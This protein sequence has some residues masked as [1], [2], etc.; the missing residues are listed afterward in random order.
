MDIYQSTLDYLMQLPV[1]DMWPGMKSVL[2]RVA[3]GRP[4]AWRL[5]MILCEAVSG[6]R[7]AAVP[8]CAALA[9]A[10]ISIILVDDML[11]EDSRGEYRSIGFGRASNFA[12]AFHSS[13]LDALCFCEAGARVRFEAVES[14]N[15]MLRETAFGQEL[16][17]QNPSDEDAY[18]RVVKN[19]SAPFYGSGFFLGALLGK[20]RKATAARLDTLG[21]LYGEMIQ[22][23][24]DLND[25]MAVPANPDWLL[26]RKPL[27]ILFAQT[28]N[29]PERSK[30]IDL[31]GDAGSQESLTRAQEILI[32]CGAVSYSID[33]LAGR[34]QDARA[35]LKDTALL[36]END[37]EALLE[38][39][40][41]PVR[42]LFEVLGDGL[43]GFN[44]FVSEFQAETG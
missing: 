7:E 36:Y 11:D 27:P 19:K 30:F 34:Y 42:N 20:A 35:I 33:C 13:A 41:M 15:R 24:D 16:D 29:H 40:I 39:L 17:V 26:G 21:R 6:S 28:V 23:H 31:C 44:L 4:H 37:V 5:P 14:L 22:I 10:Q 12:I 8:A 2:E 43:P 32:R 25:C 9:C 1:F 18:W 38:E 3:C